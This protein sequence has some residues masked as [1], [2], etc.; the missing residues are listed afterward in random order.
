MLSTLAAVIRSASTTGINLLLQGQIGPPGKLGGPFFFKRPRTA[1][2]PEYAP[3][4]ATPLL[5][6]DDPPIPGLRRQFVT[7]VAKCMGS[8]LGVVALLSELLL[9]DTGR[10]FGV[11]QATLD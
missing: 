5:E 1:V 10:P 9:N 11:V 3:R 2:A 8:R 4:R 7:Y 6:A